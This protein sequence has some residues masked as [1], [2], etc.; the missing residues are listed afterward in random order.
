M[1]ICVCYYALFLFILPLNIPFP[2]YHLAELIYNFKCFFSTV[3]SQV[4]YR[5]YLPQ[6]NI[7]GPLSIVGTHTHV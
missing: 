3:I 4:F 1:H 5:S 2:S 7:S 6:L